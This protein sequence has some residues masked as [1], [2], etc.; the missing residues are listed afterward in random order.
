MASSQPETTTV[1]N[2]S[3]CSICIDKFKTPRY[4]PCTNCLSSYI[5]NVNPQS[6]VWVFDVLC[7]TCTP[8]VMENL[9]NQRDERN[10]F[11]EMTHY[12]K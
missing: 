3:V 8:R 5:V 9:I 2:D 11:H 7:V 1:N 12:R 10:V 6:P 4:L